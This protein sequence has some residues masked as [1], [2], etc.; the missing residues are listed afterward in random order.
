M[1]GQL[2]PGYAST[3]HL[4]TLISYPEVD[5]LNV[6]LIKN[7]VSGWGCKWIQTEEKRCGASMQGTSKYTLPHPPTT[8]WIRGDLTFF[9]K[10]LFFPSI[11]FFPWGCA[12][13]HFLL[14]VHPG[15]EWHS[16]APSCI[17]TIQPISLCLLLTYDHW[18]FESLIWCSC[19]KNSNYCVRSHCAQLHL[20]QTRILYKQLIFHLRY[21]FSSQRPA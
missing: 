14:I 10:S 1:W 5:T 13:L 16:L 6:H 3:E 9:N 8:F 7:L 15:I 12:G 18:T 17:W 4:S 21:L 19:S 2:R 20:A 11:F